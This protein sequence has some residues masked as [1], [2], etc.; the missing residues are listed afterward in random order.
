MADF[1]YTA[2]NAMDF[3]YSINGTLQSGHVF[4]HS[5]SGCGD[6]TCDLR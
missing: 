3:T 2:F 6:D 1:S 5:E 4:V